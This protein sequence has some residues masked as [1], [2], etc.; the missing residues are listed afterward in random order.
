[1]DE[2]KLIFSTLL[3]LATEAVQPET[4]TDDQ[5]IVRINEIVEDAQ[6]EIPETELGKELKLKAQEIIAVQKT[7]VASPFM[8]QPKFDYEK[9]RD[10][11]SLPA[12]IAILKKIGEH[13]DFLLI[14]RKPTPEYENQSDESYSKLM[15][16]TFGILNEKGI[17]MSEY[18]YV[19]DS[20]KNVIAGLEEGV[21]QQVVG[22]RH[23]IM[24]RLFTIKNPG[25]KKFDSN[26]ATYKDLTDTLE[27]IREQT[28][29]NREDYF[30]IT[31]TE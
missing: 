19:F 7:G 14:P 16:E 2:Q 27:K 10:E 18:K 31:P 8:P 11:T 17:G 12:G 6:K 3:S 1:M 4:L 28:G 15:L 22:H 26:Y 13:S 25:T 21:M 29:N 5:K 30:T 9:L 23:E 24:S 20:M